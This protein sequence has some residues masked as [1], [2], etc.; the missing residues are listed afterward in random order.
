MGCIPSSGGGSAMPNDFKANLSRTKSI[1]AYN[2]TYVTGKLLGQGITGSVHVVNNKTTRAEYAMKTINLSRVDKSQLKELQTEIRILKQLDHPNVV[3]LYETFEDKHKIKIVMEL[4]TGGELA[5]RRLRKE[6]QVVAVVAQVLAAILHCHNNGVVHRDLKL[7]NIL[8]ESK[9]TDS[10]VKVIDFGLSNTFTLVGS[11]GVSD[12]MLNKRKSRGFS[13]KRLKEGLPSMSSSTPETEMEDV[14]AA[15]SSSSPSKKKQT[16]KSNAERMFATTCCTA[17]YMAPE[18][19]QGKYSKA[20]DLWALGVITFMLL[21]GKAPFDGPNERSI[22][23]K[24]QKGKVSY[25]SH[26]WAKISPH[27]RVF[28]ESL[29]EVDVDARWTAGQALKSPW[30][31]QY[32]K[33]QKMT[34]VLTEEIIESL[35]KFSSYAQMKKAALMV[36]AHHAD[37]EKIQQLRDAFLAMDV[38]NSG[39]I[40]VDELKGLMDEAGIVDHERIEVIFSELDQDS[41][42]DVQY[43]EFLAATVELRCKLTYETVSEAFDHLDEK[44]TGYITRADLKRL[45]GDSFSAAEIRSMISQVNDEIDSKETR[46]SRETFFRIFELQMDHGKTETLLERSRGASGSLMQTASKVRQLV[47]RSLSG[48]SSPHGSSSGGRR[49]FSSDN[50]SSTTSKERR[51]SVDE[52]A[53]LPTAFCD[54]D[55]PAPLPFKVTST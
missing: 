15:M 44:G 49:S 16:G 32:K 28:V 33:S 47:K 12:R 38:D 41:S 52:D 46:V 17:F 30:L 54:D 36:I 55:A 48:K 37:Q 51:M 20:C 19:I 34:G 2:D 26:I 10:P 14:V 3:R 11:E 27:A 29:L 22:F 35:D 24:L 53:P 9:A 42:G 21:T 45:L 43:M 7:E 18:V 4:C 39:S 1:E 6:S 8:F 5:K 40:T 25:D 50:G 23:R 31:L 13:M